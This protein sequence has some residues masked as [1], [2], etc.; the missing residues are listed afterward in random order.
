[1]NQ[2]LA[3]AG[4]IGKFEY[5]TQPSQYVKTRVAT[6]AACLLATDSPHH[7]FSLSIE[8]LT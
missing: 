1:M 2:Q 3:A 7:T 5:I 6:Y 8:K 4:T